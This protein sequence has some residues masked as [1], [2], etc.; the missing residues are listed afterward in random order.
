MDSSSS[1][2][3]SD[4]FDFITVHYSS[5]PPQ[6]NTENIDINNRPAESPVLS[7]DEAT[8][9]EKKPGKN[10]TGASSSQSKQSHVGCESSESKRKCKDF[11]Y[12]SLQGMASDDGSN[13]SQT[14]AKVAKVKPQ[15][16]YKSDWKKSYPWVQE[17]MGK[18]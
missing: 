4:P 6:R 7:N 17:V 3:D 13:Q 14:K 12:S 9:K 11:N 15:C 2:S 8:G 16:V 1:E 10:S 5:A 18:Q